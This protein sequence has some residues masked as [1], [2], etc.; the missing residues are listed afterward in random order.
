V[1]KKSGKRYLTGWCGG[2]DNEKSHDKCPR[3]TTQQGLECECECHSKKR[4]S[5]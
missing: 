1:A 5:R 2:H 3:Q 4:K